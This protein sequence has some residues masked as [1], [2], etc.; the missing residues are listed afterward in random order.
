MSADYKIFWKSAAGVKISELAPATGSGGRNGF[1]RLVYRRELNAP[2]RFRVDVPD[3]LPDLPDYAD[4]DQVE[5]YRK[6]AGGVWRVDFHG[7]FRDEAI[8]DDATGEEQVQLSGPGALA[9][10]SWYHV[11]WF[12]GVANRTV[13]SAVAAETIL[14]TLVARNAVVATATTAA[15][16]FRNAP[17]YGITTEADA[18]GGTVL[19]IRPGAYKNL[20]TTLQGLQPLAGGDFDLVK[21]GANVWEFRFYAGQRGTD[22]RGDVVFSKPLGTM[23][24]IRYELRRSAERTA[25]TIAGQGEASDR[26]IAIRTTGPNYSASNDIETVVEA[27][28][29]ERDTADEVAQLQ[30]RGDAALDEL[31]AQPVFSFEVAPTESCRYGVHYDL[32]DL[33]TAFHPRIG[34]ID[35]QI[36]A[37]EVEHEPG[38]SAGE[39][40]RVEVAQR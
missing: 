33:A 11:L 38:S 21:A 39:R 12:A 24:G 17:D 27:T 10:L 8:A 19:T 1:L 9:R 35:V 14:K 7:I 25:A 23:T 28:D 16:R 40:V 36:V 6:P 3:A 34:T 29:V 20:L 13:F 30:A 15:G 32:G 26:A 37:V 31:A 2:G 18:G 22:R 4:K 5:I